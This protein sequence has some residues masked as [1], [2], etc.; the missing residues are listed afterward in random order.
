M[1]IEH[2]NIT[3]NDIEASA[4]FYT[5]LFGGEVRWKGVTD[6][7]REAVH[8]GDKDTYLSLFQA[9]DDGRAPA[10]YDATGFNHLGFEVNDLDHFRTRLADMG[11]PLKGEEDYDPGRRLYFYDPDGIEIELVEY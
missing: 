11:V 6:T 3:V 2:A 10:D 8:I 9:A 4:R 1:R 5:D 7:G